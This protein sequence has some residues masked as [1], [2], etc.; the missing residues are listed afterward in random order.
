MSVLKRY[1]LG[2]PKSSTTIVEV[3]KEVSTSSSECAGSKLTSLLLF[4]RDQAHVWH[5]QTCSEVEHRLFQSFYDGILPLVDSFA[6]TY[7]G[8]TGSRISS[9]KFGDI[10][11]Y[12]NCECFVALL[13]TICKEVSSVYEEL[14]QY[15]GVIVILDDILGFIS[16]MK[17][18]STL[19]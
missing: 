6:E 9:I 11:D 16:K 4:S 17:Y 13:D 14:E 2:S 10:S 5:L 12:T 15:R 1:I 7:M 3:T 18:L 19:K 8:A